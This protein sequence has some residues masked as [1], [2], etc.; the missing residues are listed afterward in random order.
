MSPQSSRPE[1]DAAPPRTRIRAFVAVARQTVSLD[2]WREVIARATRDAIGAADERVCHAARVFLRDT[3]LGKPPAGLPFDDEQDAD[4][5]DEYADLTDDELRAI[6]KETELTLPIDEATSGA[7]RPRHGRSERGA[8]A[9]ASP[10]D[11]DGRTKRGR[12]RGGREPH[13]HRGRGS[14]RGTSAKASS[15]IGQRTAR[16]PA[17][18]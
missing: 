13:R 15:A 9:T 3:L 10:P 12:A 18:H 5:F 2:A 8:R 14:S 7:A 4:A 16:P 1:T 11:D 6:L 17:S